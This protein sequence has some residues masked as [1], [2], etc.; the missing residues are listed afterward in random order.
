MPLLTADEV[1]RALGAPL[2]ATEMSPEACLYAGDMAAGSFTGMSPILARGADAAGALEQLRARATGATDL[3]VAGAPALQ[4]A[5]ETLSSGLIRSATAVQPDPA[6]AFLMSADAPSSV[7]VAA[8]VVGLARQAIPF[9]AS[10]SIEP[11]P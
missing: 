1:A 3:E 6:T 4:T 7:D 11:L 8:A 5:P 10:L 2:T 9:G